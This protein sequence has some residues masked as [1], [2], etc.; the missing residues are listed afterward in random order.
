MGQRNRAPLI[1]ICL[2]LLSSYLAA[3][4]KE[5][6]ISRALAS[7]PAT[8]AAHAKVVDIDEKGNLTVL[9]DGTN[10]FTCVPGHLGVVGD[11]AA[12]MDANALQ[13]VLDF[14]A[15]KPKPTNAA[16]G[17]MYQ[18]TGASDWSASD[19]WATS[20]TPQLWAP[21]W[22][23]TWPFDPKATG[24]TDKPKKTGTWVMWAGTPY[25]HLMIMQKP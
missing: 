23:I 21:G 11:P 15:H 8:V 5:A 10:G 19:P 12:C 4:S 17:I 3:E 13:W 16:P 22:V 1:I 24:L 6:K 18:L 7:A 9:R 2:L 14:M 25:A 20:G